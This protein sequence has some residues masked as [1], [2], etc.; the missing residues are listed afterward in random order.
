MTSRTKKAVLDVTTVKKRD[1]M[2][3]RSNLTT[4]GATTT[5]QVGPAILAGNT[6]ATT[7]DNHPTALLWCATARDLTNNAGN[8]NLRVN[9][10]ARTSST[11]YMVGLRDD[12]EIQTSSGLPWQWRR[13]CFTYKGTLPGSG[14][15]TTFKP[16]EETSIGYT[17]LLNPVGGNRNGGPAYDLYFTI[18]AGQNTSDWFDPMVAKL[19]RTRISVKYDKT[20]TIAAGNESGMI[21]KYH[22]YHPMNHTLAYDD[23]ESGENMS[24]SYLSVDSKI[25]MG[26]YYVLDLVRSRY[27]A[28][29]SDLMTFGPSTTLYWH[30]K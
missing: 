20:R 2:L 15:T 16:Y 1:N 26:D 19:D 18:F 3:P 23:D 8:A 4:A 28:A 12:I 22:H 24:T 11:P 25:G 29:T 9:E 14:V 27:G 30:E 10:A 5:Y 6:S 21:R 13:I 7:T 17:R